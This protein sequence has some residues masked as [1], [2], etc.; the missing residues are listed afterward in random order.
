MAEPI[1]DD[2]VPFVQTIVH[3]TDFSAASESA[4]AHA[5]A[6]ALLRRGSLTILHVGS[7][8]ETDW[9]RFPGVR[10]MLARW[11]LLAPGSTQ[12]AVHEQL[13]IHVTKR[14]ISSRLPAIAVVDYLDEYPA[15]LLVVATE[16]RDGTARWLHGSVAEAM[17]RWSKTTTLFVPQDTRRSIITADGKLTLANI[18]VP[19]DHAP[20][21]TAA[22]EFARRAADLFGDGNVA[23][24]ILYVGAATDSPHVQTHDGDRWTFARMFRDGDPLDEILAA[25]DV[26]RAD[27]IVMATAGRAGVFEALSGSTTE[28]VLRRAH[29]AVLAVPATRSQ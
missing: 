27:L 19:I 22:I 9:S 2:E 21:A 4:F 1:A 29:C 15:D 16:G 11:G 5:L 26:V 25:A 13:G 6:V 12:A 20:D 18:L 7:E 10:A 14:S 3:P 8:S 23:I 28:R 24:T 17:A